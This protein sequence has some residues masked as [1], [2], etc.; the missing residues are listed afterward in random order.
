M[1]NKYAEA[2]CN[3]KPAAHAALSIFQQFAPKA[4]HIPGM[5]TA[6]RLAWRIA[7]GRTE[8]EAAAREYLYRWRLALDASTNG[9]KA[10]AAHCA[11]HVLGL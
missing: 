3:N 4:N 6:I 1:G 7:C 2:Y 10:W 5:D 9:S 11:P 8:A